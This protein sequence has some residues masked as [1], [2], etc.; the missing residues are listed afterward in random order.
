MLDEAWKVLGKMEFYRKKY[1]LKDRKISL[2]PSLVCHWTQG[3]AKL[4]SI[5]QGEPKKLLVSRRLVRF[6]TLFGRSVE[7]GNVIN[8]SVGHRMVW[9]PQL[10]SP[11]GRGWSLDSKV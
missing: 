8:D 2:Q 3:I 7:L 1:H 11:N 9:Q 5:K 6:P 4:E 10:M